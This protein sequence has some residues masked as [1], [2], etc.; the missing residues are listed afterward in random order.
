MAIKYNKPSEIVYENESGVKL[1]FSPVSSNEAGAMR[2][3]VFGKIQAFK[4]NTA[5]TFDDLLSV[6]M[7]PVNLAARHFVGVDGIELGDGVDFSDVANVEKFLVDLC[8]YEG[9]EDLHVFLKVLSEGQK[10]T[11]MTT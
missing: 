7:I 9:F 6:G 10:K 5:P 4:D 8:D 1:R 3:A 2:S 11:F